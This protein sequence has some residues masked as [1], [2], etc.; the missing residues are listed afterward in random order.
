MV[1]VGKRDENLAKDMGGWNYGNLKQA[2]KHI[3][4]ADV[5]RMCLVLLTLTVAKCVTLYLFCFNAVEGKG[6]AL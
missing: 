2:K 6:N 3:S 5:K 4:V 1:E